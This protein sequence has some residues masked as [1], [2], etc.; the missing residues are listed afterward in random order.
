MSA[1]EVGGAELEVGARNASGDGGRG[2]NGEVGRG[3][4]LGNDPGDTQ[5]QGVLIGVEPEIEVSGVGIEGGGEGRRSYISS[6]LPSIWKAYMISF[7]LKTEGDRVVS[8]LG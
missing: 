2:G 6:W 5:S 3:A 8:L 1:V 4:G 7:S